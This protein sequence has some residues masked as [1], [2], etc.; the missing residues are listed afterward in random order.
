MGQSSDQ[1][2]EEL[3]HQRADAGQ[4][5]DDLHHQVQDQASQA[6]QQVKDTA[7]H[8]RDQVQGTVD[9]AVHSVQNFDF[10]QQIQE[11]PLV[12]LGAALLGGFLLGGMTGGDDDDR[13]SGRSYDSAS[14]S[15]SGSG[16]GMS[17]QIRSAAQKS[18]LEDTFSNAA[19][20]IMGSVTE[21]LKGS[22]NSTFPGFADKLDTAQGKQ[23]SFSDKAKATQQE[24]QRS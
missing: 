23:G 3:D 18:G 14:G 17:R 19:A 10:Q 21:Q 24:A 11:R 20:A 4:K 9:D 6:Q 8:V 1:I 22:L 2:R 12:A 5:I 16:G 15:Q 7:E 13:H